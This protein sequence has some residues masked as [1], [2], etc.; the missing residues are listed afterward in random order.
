LLADNV[1]R[2]RTD[3]EPEHLCL[4]AATVKYGIADRRCDLPFEWNLLG[5]ASWTGNLA[6]LSISD[7]PVGADTITATYAGDATHGAANTAAIIINVVAPAPAFTLTGTPGTIDVLRGSSTPII[8]T[9]QANAGF[10]GPVT[11]ACGNLPAGTTC[12]FSPAILTLTAGSTAT[13]TA[14]INTSGGAS[15]NKLDPLGVNTE[16]AFA[17]LFALML[18]LGRHRRKLFVLSLLVLSLGTL[19]ATTGCGG[20]SHPGTS[21]P[22]GIALVTITATG[23]SGNAQV[24]ESALAI[25][26]VTRK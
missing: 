15:L 25:I 13:T 9:L 24:V 26:N 2:S 7:L 16:L 21:T 5:K 12:T 10:S 8:L 17:G 4:Q 14:T 11:F 18:P 1:G 3:N 6:E 19:G 23:T 20:S 22:T